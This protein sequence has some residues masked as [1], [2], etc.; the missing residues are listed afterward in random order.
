M[1]DE[2]VVR[3]YQYQKTSYFLLEEY[4][5]RQYADAHELSQDA[6]KERHLQRFD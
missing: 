4:D 2:K 6:A 3:A 1:L 5:H